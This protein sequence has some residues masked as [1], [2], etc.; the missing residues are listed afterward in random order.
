MIHGRGL[1]VG[2]NGAEISPRSR[3]AVAVVTSANGREL[4]LA[5]GSNFSRKTCDH[6]DSI[7]PHP[8]V[9][10]WVC[11]GFVVLN[12][13]FLPTSVTWKGVSQFAST[14]GESFAK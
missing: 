14:L 12:P 10:V 1:R 3:R 4:Y 7:L 6:L 2:A 5:V 11:F 9:C 13:W 8:C